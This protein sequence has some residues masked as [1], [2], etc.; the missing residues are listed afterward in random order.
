MDIKP[1]LKVM[2]LI[3]SIMVLVTV[4]TA[5]VALRLRAG[6]A[7][8]AVAAPTV[9]AADVAA[10]GATTAASGN[11]ASVGNT[12]AS[13]GGQCSSGASSLV[14]SQALQ[15]DISIGLEPLQM[16]VGTRAAP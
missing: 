9:A 6:S 5:M 3:L 12:S 8:S 10:A 16:P 13:A 15:G 1:H 4:V 11:A 2:G 14:E 7:L